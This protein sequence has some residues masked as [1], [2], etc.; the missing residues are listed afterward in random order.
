MATGVFAHGATSDEILLEMIDRPAG[1]IWS[2]P[3][4]DHLAIGICAQA[5]DTTAAPLRATLVNWLRRTGVAGGARLA[6]YSWP[7]PSLSAAD[8][9]TVAMAAD[10]WLLL[11]DAAGLVD[12][13][14]REGIFFAIQSALFAADALATAPSRAGAAY[15]ERVR[16]EII[17]ELSI[18]ARL[19]RGFFLPQFTRLLLDALASSARIRAV[20][21]DLAGGTQPYSTLKRRLIGTFELGFAW[22]WLR[23]LQRTA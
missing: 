1:Y 6:S 12:P 23:R 16:A 2:F 5:T 7:I 4:P 19:K 14:T 20:M 10:N 9:D 21:A 15:D 8:Y 3:R 17:A 11:G 13:I 18:A 22:K